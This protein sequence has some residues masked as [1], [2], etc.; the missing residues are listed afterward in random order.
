[1]RA[2]PLIV[3]G[4]GLIVLGLLITIAGIIL[5]SESADVEG[6]GIVFI[7]PIPLVFGTDRK[8]LILLVALGIVI[9]TLYM[10]GQR[11]I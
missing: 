10:L 6:G 2:D 5:S 1:M 8:I 3:I 11:G 4:T 7:G 9:V